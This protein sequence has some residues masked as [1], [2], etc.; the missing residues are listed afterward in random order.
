MKNIRELFFGFI[1]LFSSVHLQEEDHLVKVSVTWVKVLM[2][3][4]MTTQG[5][6]VDWILKVFREVKRTSQIIVGW[7]LLAA[8]IFTVYFKTLFNLNIIWHGH[9]HYRGK[10]CCDPNSKRM[11]RF[12]TQAL[13]T[14]LSGTVGLSNIAGVGGTLQWWPWCNI[15]D[16]LVWSSRHGF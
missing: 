10:V 12:L 8:I 14:A 1:L 3:F 15:L 2:D 11:V 9:R 16:D 4:S 7:L 13:T 6:F 5:G